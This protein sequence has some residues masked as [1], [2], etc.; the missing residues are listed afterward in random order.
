LQRNQSPRSS[1]SPPSPLHR[2]SPPPL[3]RCLVL[4][5]IGP[6]VPSAALQH[7]A[8]YVHNNPSFPSVQDLTAALKARYPSFGPLTPPQW[9]VIGANSAR[10]NP[11]GSFSFAYDAGIAANFATTSFADFD[12]WALWEKI[13]CPILILRGET[14]GVLLRETAEEMRAK[15]A[16]VV[17][18]GGVGH[19]PMLHTA[20]ELTA[21]EAFVSKHMAA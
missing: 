12:A 16:E 11:D 18:V 7:I 4:N 2:S 17:E 20:E 3:P 1:S 21:V 9:D 13:K 14:S 15:G 6:F 5:D 10:Q 8:S 19:T